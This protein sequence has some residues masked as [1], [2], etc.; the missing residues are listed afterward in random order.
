MLWLAM[1]ARQSCSAVLG[2]SACMAAG[3]A[4]T[5]AIKTVGNCLTPGLAQ[6]LGPISMHAPLHPFLAKQIG[7]AVLTD[8]VL[9]L[10]VVV[11]QVVDHFIC[12]GHFYAMVL[13]CDKFPPMDR[14]IQS[15]FTP[16]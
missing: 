9:S 10:L 1:G 4:S 5:H 13:K 14:W 12:G 16:I 7:K 3:Q 2:Y 11:Q 6:V 15:A 8:E